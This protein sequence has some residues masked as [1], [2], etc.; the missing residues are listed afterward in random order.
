M[1]KIDD[2][3]SVKNLVDMLS[4][5]NAGYTEQLA[6]ICAQCER[7]KF[8]FAFLEQ[9]Q[10]EYELM[11]FD[12]SWGLSKKP[13]PAWVENLVEAPCAGVRRLG[14]RRG[15]LEMLFDKYPFLEL[16]S[17]VFYIDRQR[18]IGITDF[19]SSLTDEIEEFLLGRLSPELFDCVSVAPHQYSGDMEIDHS[20]ENVGNEVFM[21]DEPDMAGEELQFADKFGLAAPTYLHCKSFQDV[22]AICIVAP[23]VYFPRNGP[24]FDPRD[25]DTVEVA[26]LK[27]RFML[28]GLE[29]VWGEKSWTDMVRACRSDP[30]FLEINKI[31]K[32]KIPTLDQLY[33]DIQKAS[34]RFDSDPSIV[35]FEPKCARDIGIYTKI[36]T[37]TYCKEGKFLNEHPKIKTH[38]IQILIYDYSLCDAEDPLRAVVNQWESIT[39]NT[40]FLIYSPGDVLELFAYHWHCFE[41]N[42]HFCY[43][44]CTDSIEKR[45]QDLR[46]FHTVDLGWNALMWGY[47]GGPL[48]SATFPKQLIVVQTDIAYDVYFYGFLNEEILDFVKGPGFQIGISQYGAFQGTK[49]F[50]IRFFL[51]EWDYY[52]SI[53]IFDKRRFVKDFS[54]DDI[55]FQDYGVKYKKQN[56][57]IKMWTGDDDDCD[58]KIT[59]LNHEN[60]DSDDHSW[61]YHP[62]VQAAT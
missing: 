11:K 3:D 33:D 36:P 56:Y 41:I 14:I 48:V 22:P 58:I 43:N 29:D 28:E 9:D 52:Q 35:I 42:S 59:H 26:R 32:R 55:Y 53:C 50:K 57:Q 1:R 2:I 62:P 31:L 27:Q 46:M 5:E 44:H 60:S 17:I 38:G 7:E 6:K 13:L 37:I 25:N 21:Y 54:D 23:E 19:E 61:I 4:L 39:P 51:F 10:S 16:Y 30:S 45:M 47:Q 15:H 12:A 24:S 18:T 8:C 49:W 20:V 34:G 40:V